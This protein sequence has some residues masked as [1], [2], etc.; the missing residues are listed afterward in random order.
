MKKD[1]DLCADLITPSIAVSLIPAFVSA[2]DMAASAADSTEFLG[3]PLRKQ[4]IPHLKNWAVDYELHRRAKEGIIPFECSFVFNSRKNHE[5]I[6]LRK[7]GFVLTVSQTHTF[8]S[9]PRESIFR[10]DYCIDGQIALA[11][12]EPEDSS[13]EVYAILTHGWNSASPNF[14]FCGIPNHNMTCW[15]QHA[16][17]YDIA[18]GLNIVDESPVTEEIKLDYKE[19]VKKLAK[20]S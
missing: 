14:L 16:N 3:G 18:G 9:M 15:A 19:K 2:Y 1:V 12:F 20:E 7:D 13:K 8:Q 4:I 5:H 11:E 17:L 10:N 6:E